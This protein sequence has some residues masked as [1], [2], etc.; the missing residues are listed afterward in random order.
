M[1]IL[2]LAELDPYKWDGGGEAVMRGILDKG[3]EIGHDIIIRTP[4]DEEGDVLAELKKNDLYFCCD[5]DNRPTVKKWFSSSI[6]EEFLPDKIMNLPKG[7]I[8][9]ANGYCDVCRMDYTPCNLTGDLYC[10]N[11]PKNDILRREFIRHASLNVYVSELQG[12]MSLKHMGLMDKLEDVYVCMPEIDENVF[13]N[14][15]LDRDIEF[16]YVGVLCNAKGVYGAIKYIEDNAISDDRAFFVGPTIVG[17]PR[18]GTHIQKV[19]KEEVAN[20]MNRSEVFWSRPEWYEPFGM[21]SIEAIKC[22]CDLLFNDNLGSLSNFDY[23]AKMARNHSFSGSYE[24]L[25][26]RIGEL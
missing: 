3:K 1:K 7:Y 25:W 5:M 20:Y 2:Y 10:K 13:N 4:E 9:F 12:R 16:L 19:E 24:K 11:C 26:H 17:A 22:G 6:F 23:D 15:G 18:R 21:T 14:S 8:L